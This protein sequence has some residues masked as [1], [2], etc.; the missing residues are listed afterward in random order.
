M[1]CAW[2]ARLADSPLEATWD[3]SNPRIEIKA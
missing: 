2:L 3:A 1:D